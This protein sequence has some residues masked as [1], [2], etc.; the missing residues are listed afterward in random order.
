MTNILIIILVGVYGIL[1]GAVSGVY[2]AFCIKWA[3]EGSVPPQLVA[4]ANKARKKWKFWQVVS[5]A[6]VFIPALLS[7]IILDQGHK[8]GFYL[9]NG[10]R[11]SF[12]FGICLFILFDLS[13]NLT[14]GWA[15]LY[16]GSTSE[17]ENAVHSSDFIY[18]Y[19][20]IFILGL[21]LASYA[22]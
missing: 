14:M 18:F 10:F 1:V 17:T 8:I 5:R 19:T 16:K 11:L 6:I 7:V 4:A 20:K 21:L 2:N 9:I 15:P 12:L 22:I 3:Q 13:L